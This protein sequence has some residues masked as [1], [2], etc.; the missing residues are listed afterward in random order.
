MFEKPKSLPV[1]HPDMVVPPFEDNS[2]DYLK[3]GW[4]TRN[5]AIYSRVFRHPVT[6]GVYLIKTDIYKNNDKKQGSVEFRVNGSYGHTPSEVDLPTA[7][8]ITKTVHSH[9]AH[10]FHHNPHLT[11]MEF[12]IIPGEHNRKREA[13]YTHIA[14]SLGLIPKVYEPDPDDP[15]QSDPY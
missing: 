2:E 3:G 13:I 8:H 1:Q 5:R 15:P 7:L 10:F 9:V 11:T 4:R 14:H 12:D 6:G